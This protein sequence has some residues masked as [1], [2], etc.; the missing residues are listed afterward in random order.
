VLNEDR[1][2]IL[3]E[4]IT[5]I[6]ESFVDYLLRECDK[7]EN[8]NKSLDGLYQPFTIYHAHS[9]TKIKNLE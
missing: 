4:N 3:Y 2:K 1:F 7:S 5:S 9:L 6:P 8:F